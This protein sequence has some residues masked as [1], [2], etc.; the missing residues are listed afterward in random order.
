M[1]IMTWNCQGGLDKK[2]H[3]V[4]RLA[5]D[6][7]VIQEATSNVRLA[8]KPGITSVY[9]APYAGASKGTIVLAGEPWT[10]TARPPIDGQPWVI[11]A[12]ARHSV[13]G[14]TVDVFAIWTNTGGKDGRPD[15]A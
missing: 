3:I 9:G 11:P 5:A 10:V 14:A 2:D 13:T 1:R 6:I 4:E 12:E 7:A 15:Y 8:T